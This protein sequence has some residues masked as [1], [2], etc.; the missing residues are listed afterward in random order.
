MDI[1]WIVQQILFVIFA[2]LTAALA[3]ITGPTYDNLLVPELSGSA[4]FPPLPPAVAS[5]P[6]F[7]SRAAEFSSYLVA[8]VVDPAVALVA[9]G[10]AATYFLRSGFDRWNPSFHATL[11]RMVFSVVVANFTLPLAGGL[12]SVAGAVYPVVAGFDGGAW[13]HWVNLGGLGEL[14]F[15]WDNGVLAFVLSFVLFTLVL[16]LAIAVALRDALLG[17]LLVLLPLLTILWPIPALAPLA[18]KAWMLFGELAFLPCVLVIPLE[19]AVGA[20]N[21]LILVAYLAIALASPYF[22]SLAGAQLNALGF[23]AAGST[24]S[25]GVQRGLA[26]GSSGAT[27]YVRPLAAVGSGGKEAGAA[28]AIR[29]GSAGFPAAAPLVIGEAL[30]RGAVH[31]V[32][33]L[34]RFAGVQSGSASFPPVMRGK[35]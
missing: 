27:S 20:P 8:N 2:L 7:V 10:V 16:L 28:F 13:Q 5:G 23:P 19:L 35:P 11:P 1:S 24:L 22:L 15:S 4:L 30:G 6:S 17:V 12:L 32:R 3:T 18:R 31:L 26:V 21:P 14:Q 34:P 9:I 33:H 29:A 25:A